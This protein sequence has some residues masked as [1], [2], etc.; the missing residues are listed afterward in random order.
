M[1][2]WEPWKKGLMLYKMAAL[3]LKSKLRLWKTN[4]G[5]RISKLWLLPVLLVLRLPVPPSAEVAVPEHE[6][7]IPLETLKHPPLPVRGGLCLGP[8]LAQSFC[9]DVAMASQLKRTIPTCL[10]HAEFVAQCVVP[11]PDQVNAISVGQR[12]S[13]HPVDSKGVEDHEQE[14]NHLGDSIEEDACEGEEVVEGE[15]SCHGSVLGQ[16]P[17]RTLLEE[18]D[19]SHEAWNHGGSDGEVEILKEQNP[20]LEISKEDFNIAWPDQCYHY[21]DGFWDIQVKQENIRF[22]LKNE[23]NPLMGESW[24]Y[25]L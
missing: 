8:S 21:L 17:D 9:R 5:W 11:C 12:G 23:S 24:Q 18:P 7:G 13:Q 2:N 22:E 25:N 16:K 15:E 3:N 14:E 19:A 4:F 6:H 20:N 10:H 1:P